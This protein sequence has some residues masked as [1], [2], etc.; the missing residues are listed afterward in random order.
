LNSVIVEGTIEWAQTGSL[1][2]NTK[3]L[4][5]RGGH[6]LIGKTETTE[7]FSGALAEI[8]LHGD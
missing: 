8:V 1:I 5:I 2:L 6:V 3:F 7:F 4:F